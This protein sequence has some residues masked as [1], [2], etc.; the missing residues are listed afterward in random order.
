MGEGIGGLLHC[1]LLFGDYYRDLLS[2]SLLS[3]SQK[4]GL[5]V[6][7]LRGLGLRV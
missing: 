7:S 1:K 5:K 3:T 2:H 4:H 6:L